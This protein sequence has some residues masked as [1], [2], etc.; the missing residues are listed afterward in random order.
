M[1]HPSGGGC[2]VIKNEDTPVCVFTFLNTHVKMLRISP[3]GNKPA[4]EQRAQ[5]VTRRHGHV[6]TYEDPHPPPATRC[7]QWCLWGAGGVA[8][9]TH[10]LSEL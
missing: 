4:A 9:S 8:N 1:L 6:L 3:N 5:H 2:A 10:F 7:N